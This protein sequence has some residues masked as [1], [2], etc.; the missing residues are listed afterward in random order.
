[1]CCEDLLIAFCLLLLAVERLKEWQDFEYG[2]VGPLLTVL[3]EERVAEETY[4]FG[5][6]LGGQ[7]LL[8]HEGRTAHVGSKGFAWDFDATRGFPGED[9][10]LL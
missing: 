10:H 9:I 7:C 5:M 4:V 3:A 6:L 1:M 2:V 8:L